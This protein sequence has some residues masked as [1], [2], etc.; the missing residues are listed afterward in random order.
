[1]AALSASTFSV[2]KSVQSDSDW[3]TFSDKR[4]NPPKTDCIY[5]VGPAP[6]EETN[7]GTES[8]PIG[9]LDSDLDEGYSG[10]ITENGKKKKNK[11][12]AGSKALIIYFAKMA[13][14]G[15]K[16]TIDY[17]F[18]DSLFKGGAYINVGDKHGQSILHE[19]ARNWNTDVAKY[20]IQ[21]GADINK[22]DNFGRTPLHLCAAVN[23]VE[24]VEFL[25]ENGGIYIIVNFVFTYHQVYNYM[26][27]LPE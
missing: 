2:A 13:R 10:G 21:K 15:S 6:R 8:A 1:M 9:T 3:E 19:V 20:F 25:I 17:R 7:A 27:L 22:G 24:M 23:H 5:R 26:Y 18:L 11:R 16:E 4:R 12:A 14:K